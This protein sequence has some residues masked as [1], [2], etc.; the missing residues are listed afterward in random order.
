MCHSAWI[1]HN[2]GPH[3]CLANILPSELFSQPPLGTFYEE[4]KK[5]KIKN[6]KL[7]TI[8]LCHV[9]LR[10][11]LLEVW[12]VALLGVTCLVSWMKPKR[13]ASFYLSRHYSSVK[14]QSVY[15]Q[16]CGLLHMQCECYQ[17]LE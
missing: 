17:M 9:T 13:R 10:A 3:I 8:F 4:R 1:L 15:P 11:H 14:G 2:T 5:E 16:L 7:R 12:N 6:Y